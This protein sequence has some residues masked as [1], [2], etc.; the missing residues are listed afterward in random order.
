MKTARKLCGK[1]ADGFWKSGIKKKLYTSILLVAFLPFVIIFL[2]LWRY[3]GTMFSQTIVQSQ[4]ESF[5][6]KQVQLETYTNNFLDMTDRLLEDERLPGYIRGDA[7]P[8]ITSWWLNSFFRDYIG[9]AQSGLMG[10]YLL[11]D[12][13]REYLV[14]W[15]PQEYHLSIRNEAAEKYAQLRITADHAMRSEK[16]VSSACGMYDREC[17][18]VARP[19]YDKTGGCIAGMVLILDGGLLHSMV[20]QLSAG[21]LPWAFCIYAEGE[22]LC[23]SEG[24]EELCAG[25]E[26]QEKEFGRVGWT[27][28][29]VINMSA[30]LRETFVR[31][32][33]MLLLIVIAYVIVV[34]LISH[35]VNRQLYSLHIL[36]NEMVRAGEEGNYREI[37]LPS[38]NDVSF[39]F[40]GYN[41]MV[42]KIMD[43]EQI[44]RR[45]YKRNMEIAEKQKM[46]ELKAMELEIN[47]H[48]LYNTLN[49]INSVAIEH[50]DRFVSRLL[51]GFSSTLVYMMRDRYQPVPLQEE[52]QWLGE[53]LMLQRERYAGSF[54]YEI[55]ADPELLNEKIYKLLL[56]PFVEN[57]ILHGFEGIDEGGMLTVLFYRQDEQ[58]V[59]CIS[60]NGK[61]MDQK[62]LAILRK[63][64]ADPMEQEAPGLGILNSLRRMYGYYG[65]GYQVFFFSK[66]G[67]GTKIEIRL[68]AIMPEKR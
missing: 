35:V 15:E 49:T 31:F 16:I 5:L 4:T 18:A 36:K 55:D 63:I 28:S 46:E 58:I 13:D 6:T 25:G 44:I 21:N 45:Q 19:V 12:K 40:S 64:A 9:V 51:K 32:G 52:I 30:V 47:P 33:R 17:I 56:Q 8:S 62:T 1:I 68:P 65:E 53:Y 39:L 57:A 14:N 11:T 41:Q 54:A 20:D 24:Y 37:A 67:E 61:G 43:Q 2:Y 66:K 60:D 7:N 29:C 48:Y 34:I 50:G 59:I 26:Q 3:C 38:E 22:K 27:L 10:I 23:V 42:R